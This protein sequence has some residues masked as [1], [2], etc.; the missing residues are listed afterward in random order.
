[1]NATDMDHPD[2][3]RAAL[4][5]AVAAVDDAMGDAA[6]DRQPRLSEAWQRLVSLLAL[7]PAA[8]VKACPRCGRVSMREATLC[9]YCWAR[10]SPPVT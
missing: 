10:L 4:R 1:M 5:M 7:G 9:G 8:D 3:Q 6:A 2:P